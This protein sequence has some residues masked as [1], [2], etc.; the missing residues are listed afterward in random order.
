MKI[1]DWLTFLAILVALFGGR[2]WK[3]FDRRSKVRQIRTILRSHLTQLLDDLNRIRKDRSNNI[4]VKDKNQ[5][6]IFSTT[7]FSEV[8]GYYFLFSDLLLNNVDDIELSQYPKTILFFIHYK[9]NIETIQNRFESNPKDSFLTL[10]TFEKL[11]ER[12][13][14]AIEEFS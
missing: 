12:L 10:G 4:K 3:W 7:S 14:N 1:T 11:I 13:E 8:N 6:I 2:I 9:I 5:K